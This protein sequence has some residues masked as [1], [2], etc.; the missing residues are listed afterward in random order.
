MVFSIEKLKFCLF[1]FLKFISK[2]EN[3]IMPIKKLFNGK[4]KFKKINK[5]PTKKAPKIG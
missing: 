3:K 4:K 2:N 1:K 5:F